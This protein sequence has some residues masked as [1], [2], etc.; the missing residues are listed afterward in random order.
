[1]PKYSLWSDI[2]V[3]PIRLVLLQS[4][5]NNRETGVLS[6]E[7]RG[8]QFRAR[9]ELGKL[10]H[11][12]LGKIEA[13]DAIVEFVS[14]W[15]EGIFVF[16]QRQPPPDL[17]RDYFKVSKPLDKVLLDAALACD[18]LE[19]V[20]KKLPKGANSPLEKLPDTQNILSSPNLCDPQTEPAIKPRNLQ[21]MRMLW[22]EF[23]WADASC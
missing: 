15:R 21:V 16:I 13:D 18:N 5:A 8:L 23:G 19:V 10:T 20:W 1:M 22:A 6:V 2:W 11:A 7:H 4:L 14:V 17:A 9:F 12:K 3:Q